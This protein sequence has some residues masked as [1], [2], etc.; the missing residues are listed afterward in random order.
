MA[1]MLENPMV[2]DRLWERF[3]KEPEVIGECAGCGEEIY[4]GQ[5]IYDCE[6]E[7]VH[8]DEECCMQFVG[9]KSW[10]KVAGE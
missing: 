6:G 10:C 9:N 5:D 8:Q 1:H 4:A 3:E 2:I 7:L